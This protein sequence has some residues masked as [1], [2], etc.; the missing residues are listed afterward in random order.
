LTAT[1][2]VVLVAV[3]TWTAAG[4]WGTVTSAVPTPLLALT[5]LAVT[6]ATWRP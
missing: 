1:V 3:T 5:R 4:D 2:P 6:D